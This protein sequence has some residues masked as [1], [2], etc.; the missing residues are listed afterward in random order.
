MQMKK[1]VKIAVAVAVALHIA[2]AKAASYQL[3]D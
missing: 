2:D 3:N 1:L